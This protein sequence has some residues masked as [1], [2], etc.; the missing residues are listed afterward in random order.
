MF[1]GRPGRA[2]ADLR[3]TAAHAE[4]AGVDGLWFP[5]HVV[6]FRNYQ[7]SYP[8]ADDGALRFGRRAGLYDPLVAAT[9]AAGSTSTLRV[10][11]AILI[12]PERNPVVLAQEIAAVDHAS[13][14]RFDLG[15][16][17]GWSR[18]EFDALG[19]AWERRAERTDDYIAAM[20]S[21]WRDEL[22]THA[23]EF[24]RFADVIAEPKPVQSPHPPIWVGGGRGAA[25][26]RTARLGH[27]WLGWQV[28]EAEIADAMTEL[29]LACEAEGR[30]PATV[31]RTLGVV[32]PGPA[33]DVASY[34]ET[35][36]ACGVGEV[37]VGI[38]RPGVSL[39]TRIDEFAA[40]SR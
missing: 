30:D 34:I 22:V 25:M 33:S 1:D 16:G 17:I 37:I 7:S 26:R 3:V 28:P 39:L 24:V 13:D 40:L 15:I 23:S 9:V 29:D 36:A 31:A 4:A 10:G 27:G 20:Q 21:L 32:V 12:V 38:A 14:G 35:A 2:M 5:E 18:E 8:Y 19:I 11:T 6:F